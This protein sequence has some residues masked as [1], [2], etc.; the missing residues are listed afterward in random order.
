MLIQSAKNLRQAKR[1]VTR[2]VAGTQEL[3]EVHRL[4][5]EA[6]AIKGYCRPQADGRL[7]HY[8][9]LDGIEQT[10]V[11]VAVREEQLV[12][13]VSLTVDGPYG[14]H[15][16]E[17]FQDE[18]D[19]IRAEGRTLGAMWR[20]VVAEN[21]HSG[22]DVLLDLVKEGFRHATDLG[23]QTCVCTLNPCHRKSY[24]RIWGLKA[25]AAKSTSS[26]LT[27]APAV[28]M[29]GE[30]KDVQKKMVRFCGT[31][32]GTGCPRPNP[33]PAGRGG[34]WLRPLAAVG[35]RMMKTL[36]RSGRQTT[37]GVRHDY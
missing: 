19:R 15:A 35:L 32:T 23:V 5:Y 30:M 4:T 9:W 37:S 1:I 6:Y 14:L 13:S 3:D 17:D 25:V 28:L 2:P 21:I 27:N 24:E 10:T 22:V 16:D 20:I 26:G 34:F 18:C 12:G 7:R 31:Y 11:L 33:L 8:P 36:R 29:R